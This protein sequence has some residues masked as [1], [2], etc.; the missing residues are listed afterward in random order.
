[1]TET[2]DAGAVRAADPERTLLVSALDTDALVGLLE[3]DPQVLVYRLAPAR[4][5]VLA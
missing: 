4:Q 5:E 3:P 1:M 2:R